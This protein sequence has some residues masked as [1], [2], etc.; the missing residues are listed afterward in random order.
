M[1]TTTLTSI[2]ALIEHRPEF[3][4]GRPHIAGTGVSVG[5]VGILWS[6]GFSG[7]DIAEAMSLSLAQTFG[8]LAFYLQ[9]REAIDADLAAQDDE[10]DRLAA[11]HYRQHGRI[12]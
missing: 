8:A 6:E 5:R 3:R 10:K 1:S 9:N 4:D 12:R 7:E 2:D 11:E